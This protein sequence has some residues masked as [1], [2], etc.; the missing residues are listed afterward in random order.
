MLDVHMWQ[1][2]RPQPHTISVEEHHSR[3]ARARQVTGKKREHQQDHLKDRSARRRATLLDAEYIL[4][5]LTNS[6]EAGNLL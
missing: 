3:L 4:A 1:F 2:A 5:L 6:T